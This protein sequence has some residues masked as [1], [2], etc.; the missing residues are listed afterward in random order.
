MSKRKQTL[1]DYIELPTNKKSSAKDFY[2]RVY[3]VVERIPKGKVTTYGAIAEVLGRKGSARMVGAALGAIPEGYDIKPHRVINRI[4]A[5]SAAHK[6]GSYARMRKLL[7]REGVTFI[8]E[9]VDL[10]KHFWQPK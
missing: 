9:R 10:K 3:E 2:I 4:G 6:F 1:G 5:L 7:E 8:G